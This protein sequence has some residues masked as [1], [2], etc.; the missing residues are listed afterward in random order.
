MWQENREEVRSVMDFITPSK[1]ALQAKVFVLIMRINCLP[2][3]LTQCKV[4]TSKIKISANNCCMLYVLYASIRPSDVSSPVFD[5]S[6]ETMSVAHTYLKIYSTLTWLYKCLSIITIFSLFYR[7]YIF[8]T[9]SFFLYN[10]L[11]SI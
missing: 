10:V 9:F 6:M 11:I 7:A 4:M 2:L 3:L 5:G 8:F 1:L